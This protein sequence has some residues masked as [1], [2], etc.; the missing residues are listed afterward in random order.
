MYPAAALREKVSRKM[1]LK[2][3]P[4]VD[5]QDKR[6]TSLVL[7][8]VVNHEVVLRSL[9]ETG[10]KDLADNGEETPFQKVRDRK[11]DVV[12]ILSRLSNGISLF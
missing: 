8:A 10:N 3:G 1:L 11:L 12:K 5:W 2:N 4:T 6:S 7:A 9:A